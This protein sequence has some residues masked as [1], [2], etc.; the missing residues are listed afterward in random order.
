[1]TYALHFEHTSQE[2]RRAETLVRQL[3]PLLRAGNKWEVEPPGAVWHYDGE[4]SEV[5]LNLQRELESRMSDQGQ[6]GLYYLKVRT[7][8]NDRPLSTTTIVLE[9]P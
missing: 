7:Y 4:I 3:K 5:V 1:M 2:F 6:L 8:L 9:R